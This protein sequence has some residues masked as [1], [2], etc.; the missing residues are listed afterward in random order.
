M[1]IVGKRVSCG[2]GKVLYFHSP[3]GSG[4]RVFVARDGKVIIVSAKRSR[5]AEV[6]LRAYS[7]I[8]DNFFPERHE[9]DVDICKDLYNNV[10]SSGGMSTSFQSVTKCDVGNRENLYADVPS[11]AS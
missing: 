6:L 3:F 8:H 5:S 10:M 2:Y 11:R 1:V 4:A 9:C 7:R